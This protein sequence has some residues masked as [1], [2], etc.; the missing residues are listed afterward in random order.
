MD[1]NVVDGKLDGHITVGRAPRVVLKGGWVGHQVTYLR[2]GEW[3][4]KSRV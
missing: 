3:V 1:K 4:T 2:E